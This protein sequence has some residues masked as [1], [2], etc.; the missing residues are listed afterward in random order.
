MHIIH[1]T[2]VPV[3]IILRGMLWLAFPPF[4]MLGLFVFETS[5][6]LFLQFLSPFF[7]MWAALITPPVILF[8]AF[9]SFYKNTVY[10]INN[11]HFQSV[12]NFMWY[13][14]TKIPL[15]GISELEVKKSMLQ[16]FLGLGTI[17]IHTN[18][19]ITNKDKGY[20]MRDI[21]NPEEVLD[22]LKRN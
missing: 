4:A 13:K 9:R 7:A 14:R 12:L 15:D 11:D 19:N 6:F 21:Y 18:S 20:H 22:L 17:V 2:F 10:Q 3:L 1:P 16:K 8:I 5:K